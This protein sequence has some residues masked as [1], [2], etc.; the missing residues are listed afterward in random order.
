MKHLLKYLKP[1][2]GRM[3][4]G[5]SIK[6]LG[7]M[8]ELILPYILG[9]IIDD[10]V[11]RQSVRQI[12]LWGLLMVLCA[13][14]AVTMNVTANRM[15]AKV[16]RNT[17]EA[18]RHDLFDKTMRLSSAQVDKFTVPSLESRLTSDTYNFHHFVGMMQRMGVRAP[19]LLIGG[20]VIT[21]IIDYRMAVVMF[22][23]LPLIA[24][25]VMFISKRGIPLYT[26]VQ[27]SVDGMT[28]V[29]REDAQGI[30][31]IKALS[32]TK[33]ERERYDRVNRT[34][35]HDEQKA[36]ITMA[37]TNPLMT[38]FMNVGIAGVI[39]IGGI[40]VNGGL[41]KPGRILTFMQY[42]TLISQA[43]MS[44]TRIFV[45]Y[46]KCSASAGRIAE[47]LECP[48]DLMLKSSAEF[49]TRAD[50]ISG[51]ITFEHVNFSYN[52][53]KNNLSDISFRIPRGGSLGIIGATGSG[54]STI[55]S[56]LM[57][58]YDIDSGSIRIGGRDVRTIPTDELHSMFGA[59]MQNDFLYADTIREN[60]A[61]GRDITDSRLKTAAVMAQADFI[62]KYPDGWEHM[63]TTKG[64]N[65]SGGQ[66][67]RLL[68]ARALAGSPDILILDDSSS[69]LD[70]KTDS[71]LRRAIADGTDG[72]T[73]IVVAQRISSVMNSDVI[74]V[75]DE[76]R[77]IGMGNHDSL[78][79]NCGVYREISQSQMG[80]A[81]LE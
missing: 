52:K 47:A 61:F 72:M 33:Y 77:I 34:L 36:G 63:L 50:G 7:T 8:M 35:V 66:K 44:V 68:I 18:V 9:Y 24:L 78:M 32:K 29:V 64:T 14:L 67:Q 62:E 21:A 11:P 40:L 60:V 39:L 26:Q 22:A 46:T 53:T 54:K 57:R 51:Y 65:I 28:R 13:L 74:I 79:Q 25:A 17:S 80:G 20:G 70:Y 81:F 43:M 38:F 37:A 12:I 41:S 30:R 10:V 2:F 23:I 1:F 19:I 76:G 55:I 58:L 45:M 15:A 3:T 31:V 49:P 48:E 5:L 42:F 75:L 71:A 73:V 59:V 56:L 69:A 16:A 27:R 6:F 4:I